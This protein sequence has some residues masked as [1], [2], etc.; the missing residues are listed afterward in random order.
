MDKSVFREKKWNVSPGTNIYLFKESFRRA[1][2][3]FRKLHVLS[4]VLTPDHM[5]LSDSDH[6]AHQWCKAHRNITVCCF[7]RSKQKGQ[8]SL[9]H[10]LNKTK[11]WII[12]E[13]SQVKSIVLA[14]KICPGLIQIQMC[15][16][17]YFTLWTVRN[18]LWLPLESRRTLEMPMLWWKS[19][20]SWIKFN[21]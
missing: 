3:A 11:H 21:A 17:C 4:L 10:R 1:A 12:W 6:I 9:Q 15:S 5:L 14:F 19:V 20:R 13:L 18:D 16:V 2:K 8:P 7:W